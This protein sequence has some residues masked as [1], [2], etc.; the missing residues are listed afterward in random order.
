MELNFF[1]EGMFAGFLL[2]LIIIISY[3]VIREG[4]KK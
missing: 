4:D 1:G 3:I 2:V